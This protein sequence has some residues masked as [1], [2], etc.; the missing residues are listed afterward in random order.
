MGRLTFHGHAC[1]EIETA[2]G[3]RILVDPFLTGN[4]VADV[5]PEHFFDRLDYLLLT[6]GH[7]D[8]VGDAWGL[9]SRT[10][11]T[12]VATYEIVSYAQAEQ[13]VTKAHPMHI[14]GGWEFPF[15]RVKPFTAERS[16]R[17]GPRA[18]RPFLPAS[19]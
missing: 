16:R 5:G 14:G 4:P 6:H 17:S 18:T 13:G 15:G 10:E 8:H 11:A 7:G 9:L 12:L 19:S 1:V 3:T 2:D